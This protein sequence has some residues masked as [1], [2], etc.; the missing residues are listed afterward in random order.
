MTYAPSAARRSASA[1]RSPRGAKSSGIS[2]GLIAVAAASCL[3]PCL[4]FAGG[5]RVSMP[6]GAGLGAWAAV[7]MQ[8]ET[9]AD[10]TARRGDRL[11]TPRNVTIEVPQPV[12]AN[13]DVTG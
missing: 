11:R 1:S 4:G 2:T 7:A 10:Y 5:Y 3:V 13:A 9:P 8:V 12:V 6:F